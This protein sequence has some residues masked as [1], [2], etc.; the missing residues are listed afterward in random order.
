MRSRWLVGAVT[1]ALIALFM[2]QLAPEAQ[3]PETGA[4]PGTQGGRGARGG[5]GAAGDQGSGRAARGG[6]RGG[7][8]AREAKPTPRWPDGRANLSQAPG[9]TGSWN[10]GTGRPAG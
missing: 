8:P 2:A 3:A 9:I 1:A 7:R 6:R 5:R 10:G 4:P